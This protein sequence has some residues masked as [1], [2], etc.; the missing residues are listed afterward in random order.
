LGGRDWEDQW[1]EAS[2]GK[3][4]ETVSQPMT[5][6]GGAQLIPTM[7]ES[8][9]R[10]MDVQASLGINRDPISKIAN[11]KR[12]EGVT[13]LVEHQSSKPKTLSTNPSTAKKKKFFFNWK[14][15][16]SM[17]YIARPCLRKIKQKIS[18]NY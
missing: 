16:V 2:L 14:F 9:D 18:K 6:C 7:Q 12:A 11:A 1:L 3:V 15:E 17:G 13:Q 10:R 8:T 5:G 4:L